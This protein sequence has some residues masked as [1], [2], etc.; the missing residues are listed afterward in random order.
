M[1]GLLLTSTDGLSWSSLPIP[2]QGPV[3]C[4]VTGTTGCPAVSSYPVAATLAGG[5]LVLALQEQVTD[6]PKVRDQTVTRL[7]TAIYRAGEAPSDPTEPP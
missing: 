5:D 6:G 7:Q 4:A 1:H 2:A 3:T